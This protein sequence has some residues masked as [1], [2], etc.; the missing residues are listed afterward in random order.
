[1]AMA[2]NLY[3]QYIIH[4]YVCITICCYLCIE[5]KDLEARRLGWGMVGGNNVHFE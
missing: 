5:G 2:S 3:T 4:F 1:M